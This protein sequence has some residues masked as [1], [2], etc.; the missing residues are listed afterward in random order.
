[1]LFGIGIELGM[2]IETQPIKEKDISINTA[3]KRKNFRLFLNLK[4]SP[5][6]IDYKAPYEGFGKMLPR[7][8]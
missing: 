7:L 1:M 6:D 8:F 5:F 4:V 2:G 3:S